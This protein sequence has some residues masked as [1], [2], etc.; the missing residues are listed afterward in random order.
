MVTVRGVDA[1]YGSVQA[2]HGVD[3]TIREGTIV[4]ILGPNGAGKST[5]LKTI[6]GV[7]R[8]RRGA[9]VVGGT[10]VTRADPAAIVRRGVVHCPEGRHVFPEFTVEENL[11][12]GAYARGEGSATERVFALFPVLAER[13]RQRAGTLSGGEQQMLAIG[14]ALMARPRVLLL[15]EPSLGLAP[16][17]VERIFEAIARLRED[18]VTIA[19]V[20]QNA[21][22]ALAIADDAYLLSHGTVRF[23]GT[24]R[25]LAATE[26]L[27][28]AYLGS[29]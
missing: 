8:A 2:L 11:R 7:V 27:H 1:F 13:R 26:L 16:I 23:A 5:L 17:L 3:L 6:S 15:D 12:V 14:R 20:E 10:D 4:A 24:A 9:I 21:A 18:G 29:T 22:L 28:T 19:L 25:D